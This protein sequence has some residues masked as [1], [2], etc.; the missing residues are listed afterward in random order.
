[1]LTFEA[2]ISSTLVVCALLLLAQSSQNTRNPLVNFYEFLQLSD[3][4]SAV[5]GCDSNFLPHES[6]FCYSCTLQNKTSYSQPACKNIKPDSKLTAHFPLYA[7]G[8][9]SKISVSKFPLPYPEE[10]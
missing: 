9:M 4:A 3:Y 8:R 5:A 1:M 10:A 6:N 7:G 2:A